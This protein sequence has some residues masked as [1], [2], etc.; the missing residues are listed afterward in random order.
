MKVTP[1]MNGG[2]L[3]Y[4][5]SKLPAC[6]RSY[7]AVLALGRQLADGS[8]ICYAYSP[9][10]KPKNPVCTFYFNPDTAPGT[11]KVIHEPHSVSHL[12]ANP[13]FN[14]LDFLFGQELRDKLQEMYEDGFACW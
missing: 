9:Q 1:E 12:T 5:N 7:R 4:D 2:Q 6:L 14:P 10:K 8:Y 13:V 3:P 11:Y